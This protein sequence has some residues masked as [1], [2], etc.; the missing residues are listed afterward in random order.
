MFSTA[1]PTPPD[2]KDSPLEVDSNC[3]RI[4]DSALCGHCGCVCDVQWISYRAPWS[5][6]WS[7]SRGFWLFWSPSSV[8]YC[9]CSVASLWSFSTGST[10]WLVGRNSPRNRL[11]SSWPVYIHA[12]GTVL[13]NCTSV[14]M[15]FNFQSKKQLKITHKL[16]TFRQQ[17]LSSRTIFLNI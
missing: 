2:H 12:P 4:S 8:E 1:P 16:V 10:R 3:G 13:L 7:T 17:L 11:T 14:L 15:I 6:M 9:R 5:G